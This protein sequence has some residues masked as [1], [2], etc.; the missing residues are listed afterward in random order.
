M[1]ITEKHGK[2]LGILDEFGM[3]G[4]FEPKNNLEIYIDTKTMTEE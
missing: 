3:L 2:Q 1:E 4:F